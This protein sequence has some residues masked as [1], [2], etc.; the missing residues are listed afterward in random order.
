MTI[1]IC[2]LCEKEAEIQNSHYIPSALYPKNTR[3]EYSTST[4]VGMTEKHVTDLLLC[5]ECE[6][7]FSRNG[8]SEVLRHVAAKSRKRFPLRDKMSIAHA[9]EEYPDIQRF[10]GYDFGLDMDKFAYFMLSILWRG[11]AHRW[12]KMDGTFTTPLQLGS[13]ES[14]IRN[15]L[16]GGPFPVDTAIIVIVGS[17][18]TSRNC[19]F[20]PAPFDDFGLLNFGFHAMGV[21]F[22]AI[23]GSPLPQLFRE[24]CCMSACRC[25][26]YGDIKRKTVEALDAL[27]AM[28]GQDA[29]MSTTGLTP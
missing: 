8:E 10:A 1:G 24:F 5:R 21:Y 27:D 4:A 26:F 22:R 11:A 6:Q 17:D 7:R 29:P 2:R 18:E 12:T 15:Y 25:I 9:R 13:F 16:L 28:R 3:L 14:P 20:A 19:W 23:M